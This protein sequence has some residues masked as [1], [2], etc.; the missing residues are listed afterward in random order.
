MKRMITRSD[1]VIIINVDDDDNDDGT[2][3]RLSS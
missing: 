1:D 2:I 3:S